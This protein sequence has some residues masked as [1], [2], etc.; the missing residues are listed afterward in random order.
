MSGPPPM[1]GT[2][3][4][5]TRALFENGTDILWETDAAG[6]YNYCSPNVTRILGYEIAEFLGHTVFDF[7]PAAEARDFEPR[8][9]VYTSKHK[10]FNLLAHVLR[11]KDGVLLPFECSGAPVFGRDGELHGYRGVARDVSSR[12]P[13][14]PELASRLAE[15]RLDLLAQMAQEVRQVL[16]ISET[17]ESSLAASP[18]PEQRRLAETLGRLRRHLAATVEAVALQGQTGVPA[19]R[20]EAFQLGEVV[21]DAMSLF[22]AAAQRKG[23]E[24]RSE[25]ASD[26]PV[27]LR[28][29]RS[30]L[31]RVLTHL[32]AN[33]LK[34]ADAGPIVLRVRNEAD[35]E[36]SAI[37]RFELQDRGRGMDGLA[38]TRLFD[39]APR[40]V[41]TGLM[42]SRELLNAMGGELGVESR[43]GQGSTF[44]FMVPFLKQT[45]A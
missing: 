43:P 26:V 30:H 17:C 24:L 39:P 12:N 33:A 22:A 29:D 10:P 8:L 13:N 18:G 4:S 38:L 19:V 42:T 1:A 44:W 28:G 25:I 7:M 31:A 14:K 35:T 5:A 23:V 6:L 37:L 34:H 40:G 27:A 45:P 16:S 3:A 32:T 21:G 15:E 2:P 11:R 9:R 36:V 20:R 41:R